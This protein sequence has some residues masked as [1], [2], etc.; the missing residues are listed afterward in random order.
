MTTHRPANCS[1]DPTALSFLPGSQQSSL[2]VAR[3]R[4]PDN[5]GINIRNRDQLLRLAAHVEPCVD[6]I[7]SAAPS[8]ERL[9]GAL[10]ES[11]PDAAM[12]RCSVRVTALHE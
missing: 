8:L 6:C 2:L 9:R 1:P 11:P 12:D 5:P 3:S 4:Q 10:I 7:G